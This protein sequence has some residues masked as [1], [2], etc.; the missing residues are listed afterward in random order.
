MNVKISDYVNLKKICSFI[1]KFDAEFCLLSQ[2]LL[3]YTFTNSIKFLKYIIVYWVNCS[4]LHSTER[5]IKTVISN[6]YHNFFISM[7]MWFH[8]DTFVQT[9]VWKLFVKYFYI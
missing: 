1:R 8:K 2:G 7:Y 5:I 9:F 4:L 6:G 3:L